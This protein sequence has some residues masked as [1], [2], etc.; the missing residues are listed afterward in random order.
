M[1]DSYI[2]I[3]VGFPNLVIGIRA[4]K[5]SESFGFYQDLYSAGTKNGN[6]WA[7]SNATF[8]SMFNKTYN[9]FSFSNITSFT[10]NRLD[11]NTARV[12]YFLLGNKS[13]PLHLA[14]FVYPDSLL[15]N[16][17]GA[18]VRQGYGLSLIHI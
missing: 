9:R 2:G 1:R 15:P 13:L 16:V 14:H 5:T 7:V 8:Y 17:T 4:W 18:P 3:K 10:N 6:K 12:N 11:K